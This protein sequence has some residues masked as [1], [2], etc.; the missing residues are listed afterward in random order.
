M[1]GIVSIEMVTT[2]KVFYFHITCLDSV[3]GR[4]VVTLALFCDNLIGM[5]TRGLMT[6]FAT[7]YKVC[8]K[9]SGECH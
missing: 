6:L 5:S 2:P 3:S 8:F 7:T 9:V 4:T 1:L